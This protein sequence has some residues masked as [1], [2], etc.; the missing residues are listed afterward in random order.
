MIDIILPCAHTTFECSPSNAKMSKCTALI[1][2]RIIFEMVDFVRKPLCIASRFAFFDDRLSS[3]PM[4]FPTHSPLIGHLVNSTPCF[5]HVRRFGIMACSPSVF[6]S[7][8]RSLHAAI[9]LS[10]PPFC[11]V[12]TS[13]L[14]S[15]SSYEGQI[16]VVS[17]GH[18][19]PDSA[20]DMSLRWAA[21]VFRY[22]RR[23]HHCFLWFAF[24]L[25]HWV[26]FQAYIYEF[27]AR[28]KE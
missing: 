24:L 13:R 25:L 5:M 7:P 17:C 8:R 1:R 3:H 20:S 10:Q 21:G 9:D 11:G 27:L 15:E 14:H 28:K 26:E 19:L 18:V 12:G 16:T 22:L 4:S 2:L 6:Q 23:H